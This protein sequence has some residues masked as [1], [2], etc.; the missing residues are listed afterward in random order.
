MTD[1]AKSLPATR[2]EASSLREIGSRELKLTAAEFR[3]LAEVPDTDVWLAN[4]DNPNTRRAYRSDVEDFIGFLGIERPDDLRGVTR[5]HVLAWRSTLEAS[6]G[7]GGTVRRKLSAVSSLFDHLCN[8]NAVSHNPVTG[9]KRPAADANEGKTP[10]LSDDQARSLLNAP[11]PDTLKGKRD[12]AILATYLYHALRRSEVAGLTVGSI[13]ER[14]GVPHF[15]V[16][17]KGSKTRYVPIHPAALSAIDEY[18]DEAGQDSSGATSGGGGG[19][20]RTAPLFRPVKNNVTGDL[21]RGITGD[22]IYRMLK[23]YGKEA[24]IKLDGLCLHALRATAATNALEHSADIAYVQ[25]WLGHANISTTR[26]YDRR[27]VRPEES[28]TFKVAY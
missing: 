25:S 11:P 23:R 28:P 9:V 10:A 13:A 20:D 5:A 4:F 24:G 3:G 7:S 17:G 16:F 15:T 1:D 6:G 26:L 22:G 19:G 21:S 14:R 27:N 8:V 2:S 18:L 12:R